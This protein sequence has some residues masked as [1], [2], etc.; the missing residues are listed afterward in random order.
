MIGE[1]EGTEMEVVEKGRKGKEI[2]GNGER[3]GSRSERNYEWEKRE[4]K[5]KKNEEG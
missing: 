4:W 5:R 2:K 1:R 3:E